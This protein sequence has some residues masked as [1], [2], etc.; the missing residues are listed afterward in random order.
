M[1]KN[2]RGFFDMSGQFT[3]FIVAL[4]IILVNVSLIAVVALD[5]SLLVKMS[6]PLP[7]LTLGLIETLLIVPLAARM[8]KSSRMTAETA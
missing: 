3:T 8:F 1:H 5:P 6:S 4:S 7:V 2:E